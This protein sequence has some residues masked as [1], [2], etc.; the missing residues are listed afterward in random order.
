MANKSKVASATLK[1]RTR[2][3]KEKHLVTNVLANIVYISPELRKVRSKEDWDAALRLYI[4][5]LS[6]DEKT[7]VQKCME[8]VLAKPAHK[9]FLRE[10]C[11]VISFPVGG[12]RGIHVAKKA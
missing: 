3:S 11:P 5:T 8:F 9:E 7:I 4:N 1:A 2:K 12:K 6:C 10:P